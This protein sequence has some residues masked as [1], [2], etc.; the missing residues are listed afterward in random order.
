M[1][2]EEL[3]PVYKQAATAFVDLHDTPHRMLAKKVILREVPWVASREFFFWRL[4][5]QLL[6]FTL[7]KSVQ[8][9]QPEMTT[10]EAGREVLSWLPEV[11]G[12]TDSD[13]V[14]WASSQTNVIHAHLEALSGGSY[15][16]GTGNHSPCIFQLK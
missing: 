6:F 14:Q 13:F 5:R 1:R 7:R 3:L 16:P 10:A 9:R 15:A 12:Q 2:L 4:K 8:S 11:H